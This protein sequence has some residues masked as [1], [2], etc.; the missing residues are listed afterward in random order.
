MSTWGKETRQ[1]PFISPGSVNKGI[2]REYL[3]R[4]SLKMESRRLLHNNRDSSSRNQHREPCSL[5]RDFCL[6]SKAAYLILL[7]TV[8]VGFIYYSLLLLV[9]FSVHAYKRKGASAAIYESI[10]YAV[11]A[12]IMMFYPL[13]GLIADVCCGRLKTVAISLTVLLIFLIVWTSISIIS[14]SMRHLHLSRNISYLFSSAPGITVFI[15][16]IISILLFV[17]GLSGY[18]ANYIQLGLD[19]LFEAPSRYLSLFIHY[20]I[21]A[22]YISEVPVIAVSILERYITKCTRIYAGKHVW[23]A[24]VV[25]SLFVLILFALFLSFWKRQWFM[26]DSGQ[27]NPYK[28]V[29]K[30]ISFAWK[31]KNPL[32]RTA[33]TYGD[34]YI[35]TRLDFAKE[36]FGGPFTTEQV[37]DVKVLRRI[38][39]VLLAIG[40]VFVLE[41]PGSE[42]VFPVFGFHILHQNFNETLTFTPCNAEY[43]ELW[44]LAMASGVFM[45]IT[46]T[47]VWFPF[48]MWIIFCY[49]RN[50]MPKVFT[51]MG[52]GIVLSL[53]GVASMVIIEIAGHSL[54][55]TGDVNQTQCM[56]QFYTYDRHAFSSYPE[57]NM[58]WAVL[59]VPSL[60]LRIGPLL[61]IATTLEFI[62]A[63][64]PHS[65]KGVLIGIFFSIR[66]LFQFLN[67]ITIIPL[68]LKRPWAVGKMIEDPPVTNC[69]F[70]YLLLTFVVG[71]T[72]LIMF[73]LAAKRY[74]YRVRDEGQFRQYAIEEIY[75]RYITQ[76]VENTRDYSSD[77]NS[78]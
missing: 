37:E 42:F 16:T 76:T 29:F 64:S 66:G 68:S 77:D 58:H 38:I 21:L 44:Q 51:R 14:T 53:I 7:W 57:L 50:R 78:D 60:F 54:N 52:V 19:Q 32:R 23:F 63:Q 3:S 22:F 13:S 11:L 62:S 48:Y 25:T 47:I 70:V 69:G 71:L 2:E 20:A 1:L 24:L 67:T 35:P 45:K 12:F 74:T 59:I 43:K 56:F 33:F 6:P 18:Q 8:V 75:D 72:G 73:S 40:P 39:V 5:A 31:H 49:F 36:R 28:T 15:L 55:R 41:M 9:V 65:M 17:A 26:S 4:K 34:D 61:I 27:S 10:T 30:V 46:S